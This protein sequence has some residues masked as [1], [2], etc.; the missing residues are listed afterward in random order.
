LWYNLYMGEE[1]DAINKDGEDMMTEL[2][3]DSTTV[4]VWVVATFLSTVLSIAL[5]G[6]GIILL[7]NIIRKFFEQLYVI[8]SLLL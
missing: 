6:G 8:P 5:V 4:W 1:L 2:A 3:T 7:Y